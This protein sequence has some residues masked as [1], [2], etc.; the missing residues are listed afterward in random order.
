MS[1]I[2]NEIQALRMKQLRIEKKQRK[3]NEDVWKI[4][5]A[6]EVLSLEDT[7]VDAGKV[8]KEVVITAKKIM[9]K[10]GLKFPP[11]K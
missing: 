10:R 5:A 8:S 3:D 2:R 9:Q 1:I 4:I 11:K 7:G 6:L